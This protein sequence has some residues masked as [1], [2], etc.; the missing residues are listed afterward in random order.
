MAPRKNDSAIALSDSL[1]SLSESRDL[2]ILFLDLCDSTQ[3]KQ[4]CLEEDIPESVWITRQKVFLSRSAR[5]VR[6]YDGTIIKTIGDEIMATFSIKSNPL[7]ILNCCVETFNTFANLKSYN[8]GKFKITCKA[9]VDFGSCYDGEIFQKNIFD[10]IGTPVD[11]C[12]RIAKHALPNSIVLSR[13]FHE[14]YGQSHG[15]FQKELV[16]ELTETFKGLGEITFYRYSS[17]K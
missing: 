1:E 10:P 16:E 11:R 8:K 9:A 12:A 14:A 2:F 4:Y 6:H 13:E 17:S 3:F 5:I 7:S 15:A